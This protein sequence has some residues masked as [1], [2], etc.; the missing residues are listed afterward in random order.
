[1]A[2]RD[3]F[4]LPTNRLTAGCSTAELPGNTQGRVSSASSGTWL[5][6]TGN[7]LPNELRDRAPR[8]TRQDPR[9]PIQ[10]P[11]AR[12]AAAKNIP[13]CRTGR[14]RGGRLPADRRFLD[15]AS[16]IGCAVRRQP[17]CAATAPADRGSL[18]KMAR[19]TQFKAPKKKGPGVNPAP[20]RWV[21]VGCLQ[22]KTWA[23]CLHKVNK[24]LTRRSDTFSL[25]SCGGH[26]RN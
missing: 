20:R 3:R 14:G 19:E 5:Y 10:P 24:P 7:S 13:W 15:A 1:M 18:G 21:M 16:G 26:V 22:G 9:R 8:Q 25:L 11:Y 17:A 12:H 23:E 6:Q 2:P 4:E